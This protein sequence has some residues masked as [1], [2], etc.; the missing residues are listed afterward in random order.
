MGEIG[1]QVIDLATTVDTIRGTN[2]AKA[3][4]KLD[5]LSDTAYDNLY[6]ALSETND[7]VTERDIQNHL[8]Q[9]ALQDYTNQSDF[10]TGGKYTRAIQA[11]TAF[12]QGVMGNNIVIAIANGSAPYF[13]NEVKNQIQGNSV[14]SDIQRTI[15][16]GLLN[17]GLALAKGEN[18]VV[19]ASGAMTGETVGILSHSL[20]GKTPEELTETEKQNIS[21]WATLTSGIVGGLISDNSAGVAN[22]A[23]AGKVV[24]ENNAIG[25]TKPII[26][27][28]E[29]GYE[30]CIKNVTCRNGLM[31]SGVNFGLTSAQIQE[32]MDA[33]AAARNGDIKAMRN[34]SPEQVAYIDEQIIHNKGLA[35]LIFGSEPWGGRLGIPS[36]T[37]G[38]QM[39]DQGQTDTGGDQISVQIWTDTGGDQIP[40]PRD[41]FTETPVPEKPTLDDIVYLDK[42]TQS[43]HAIEDALKKNLE[44]SQKGNEFS[45]FG[46]YLTKEEQVF[47]TKAHQELINEIGKFK[48]NTQAEKIATMIGAYDSKTGKTA[49]G[50]SNKEIT[51]DSLHPTTVDYIKKQLGVEIGEFTHFCKNKVGACAEVSAADS[52]VRQGAK[53]GNIKFTDALR[54]KAFRQASSQENGHLNS[55]K[56]IIETC[57]NCKVTWP[58]EIK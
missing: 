16:H 25:A 44:A 56:I 18:A 27:G 49:V 39:P 45:K 22:A 2:Q 6:Q 23:Q 20:Y 12:T 29:K 26:K 10:G 1:A 7:N 19:Q 40:K 54:P 5:N 57:D 51:A 24:V 11:I 13:A 9:Q 15:T 17:A 41:S 53:P 8:F 43:E 46:D 48:S 52:L 35:R 55:E 31:Q 4:S 42:I 3:D 37:G 34:L 28:L 33:G 58:K 30:W 32:A 21:A 36:H 47:A 50:Y 14:E 38:N